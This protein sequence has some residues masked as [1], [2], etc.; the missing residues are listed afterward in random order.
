MMAE[1]RQIAG[2]RQINAALD[3][4]ALYERI[5]K[6]LSSFSFWKQISIRHRHFFIASSMTSGGSL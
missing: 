2:L 4:T 3:V 6:R 1:Q 5:A